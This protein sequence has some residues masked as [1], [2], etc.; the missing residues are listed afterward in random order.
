VVG[1]PFTGFSHCGAV[2]AWTTVPSAF[3]NWNLAGT[4]A[5]ALE[6]A[7]RLVDLMGCVVDRLCE[8]IPAIYHFV[9]ARLCGGVTGL[10]LGRRGKAVHAY[11]IRLAAGDGHRAARDTRASIGCHHDPHGAPVTVA[12]RREVRAAVWAATLSLPPQ[13]RLALA[14]RERHEMSYKQIAEALEISVPAVETMLFRARQGFRRAYLADADPS[15]TNAA[16]K[17]TVERLSAPID[18]ELR[19][20]DSARIDAHLPGCPT[21][22]FAARE[23]RVATPGWRAA[24]RRYGDLLEPAGHSGP[25]SNEWNALVRGSSQ[26]GSGH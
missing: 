12:E 9:R 11:S 22:Q 25:Y 10:V 4:V 13:Q 6:N 7:H 2:I 5:A 16:C 1:L 19:T 3:F 26:T 15:P 21:C 14:L 17:W 18:G 23:L 24:T 8:A 20:G